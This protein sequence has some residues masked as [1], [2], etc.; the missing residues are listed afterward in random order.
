MPLSRF[1]LF[2]GSVALPGCPS[3]LCPQVPGRGCG[4]GVGDCVSSTCCSGSFPD[5]ASFSRWEPCLTGQGQLEKKGHGRVPGLAGT[6]SPPGL[7]RQPGPGSA[8]P[9]TGLSHP[10]KVPR[11]P[12][13]GATWSAYSWWSFARIRTRSLCPLGSN[14]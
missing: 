12:A 6:E 13:A 10:H 1:A 5:T 8:G 3:L 4:G 2:S 9:L 7:Q 11:S 14:T